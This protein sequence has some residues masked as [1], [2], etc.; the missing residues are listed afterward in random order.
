MRVC[1]LT[2]LDNMGNN[3]SLVQATAMLKVLNADA[4]VWKR[5]NVWKKHSSNVSNLTKEYYNSLN[6]KQ[7]FTDYSEAAKYIN[8]HY[9]VAII[10]SDELWKAGNPEDDYSIPYPNPYWGSGI[11]I[12]KFAL[13][14]S[15]G[16]LDLSQYTEQTISNMKKD[17]KDFE[18]IYVRDK[19]S[20]LDL[21]EL[22][23]DINGIIPDPSF[24]IDFE[25]TNKLPTDYD[26]TP[27]EWF[28]SF[29]NLDF[30]EH[31]RMHKLLACIRGGTPCYS[32]DQRYK[33]KELKDYFELPQGTKYEIIK[34]WPYKSIAIKCQSYRKKWLD[35]LY[36]LKQVYGINVNLPSNEL[37]IPDTPTTPASTTYMFDKMRTGRLL[38]AKGKLIKPKL[39]WKT[40]LPNEIPHSAES[41]AVFDKK[42]NMYFGCHD[43]NFYSLNSQGELRWSLKT[44]LKI[45]SSPI[46]IPNTNT[47][48]FAGGD[49][50]CYCL[51]FDGQLIWSTKIGL[52]D[53][54]WWEQKVYKYYQKEYPALHEVN[55]FPT[56][57]SWSSPNILSDGSICITGYTLG[58][59]VMN[60]AT[61]E[62]KWRKKLGIPK[63]HLAGVAIT[64]KDEIV[65]VSQQK[66]VSK[67]D[68]NGNK[69]W[70]A[71][72][73]GGYNAWG[74]PSIDIEHQQIYV[75]VSKREHASVIY[76][77]SLDG[78]TIWQTKLDEATRGTVAISYEDYVVVCGFKGQM[79]FL[80]K[81]TGEVLRRIKVTSG[82]M[83]TSASIDPNGFIFV[84][85]IDSS[86]MATGRVCCYDKTGQFVWDFEMGKGHS[87]PIFDTQQRLYFGS[88]SGEYFCI[89]T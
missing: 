27:L 21:V 50:I 58:L 54:N 74:N 25:P 29:A 23:V 77:L 12:K 57:N 80:H 62:I 13:A 87:V 8:S 55:R 53:R 42:G 89:K 52:I 81:K 79:Y 88:W 14:V 45:Y 51:N 72:L 10:G 83:W 60:P 37:S 22:G 31:E 41:S 33:S 39:I 19:K 26:I 56:V 68:K 63:Y 7:I 2:I 1:V 71:K 73:K 11:K 75:S 70:S 34:N 30:L 17:L 5:E 4:I 65:A 47:L 61:G 49:G 43:G 20:M 48:C 78:Q 6:I 69:Q 82:K 24:A 44:S 85:V 16:S 40:R 64:N 38:Y 86:E 66:K 9:D 84:S 59:T 67:F 32:Y 18:L 36:Q 76:A 15:T 46:I 35:L 3:G 28:A